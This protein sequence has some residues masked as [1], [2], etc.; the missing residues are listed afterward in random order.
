MNKIHLL[1]T[2]FILITCN[3]IFSQVL[4]REDSLQAGLVSNNKAT[5]LSGYGNFLYSHN[6]TLKQSTANVQ[7]VVLFIGHKFNKRIQ[8]FSEMEIEDAGIE[9]GKLHGS[10]ALEQAFLKFNLDRNNYLVGGLFIPRLGIINENHLPT[11][12][13]GNER[14][15]VETLIIPATWR[16][17]GVGYYGKTDRIP[18]LNYSFG[19]LT[20]LNSAGFSSGTG[21]GD[22]RFEGSMAKTNSLAL[23]GA[24]LYYVKNWR[25]QISGYYGGSAGLKPYQA[26]SLQL[27]SGI[28]GTPV[29]LVEGNVQYLGNRLN[30]KALASWVGISEAVS[31]NRAY[32]SN[33][34]EQMLG[35]YVD[36]SYA[37]YKKEQ[38]SF[39]AFARYEYLNMNYKLAYNGIINETLNQQYIIAGF[40]YSPIYNVMIKLD[41]TYRMTG[42]V[43]PALIVTPYP[44]G[45]PYYM[46]Q[47]IFNLGVGYS[48]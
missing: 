20:G 35:A 34:P 6:A 38:A 8:L 43:N 36:V 14:P 3:F 9:S 22:G 48:F 47:H 28:F 42:D 33:T 15:F 25:F 1:L 23:T 31:I 13:N 5:I 41:Y 17:I 24:L 10:F 30:V 27:E 44:V 21:I 40:S 4:T 32:A 26:D 29:T 37:L 7:R 39:K 19:L 18:G 46:Q 12:F 16:E 11:T 45:Q 2:F